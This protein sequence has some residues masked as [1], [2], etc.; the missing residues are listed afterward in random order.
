MLLGDCDPQASLT[1]SLGVPKPDDLSVTLPTLMRRVL[2]E[3]PMNP[4]EAIIHHEEGVDLLPANIELA[5]MELRLMSAM[6]R[7]TIL[8]QVLEP[9]RKQYDHILMWPPASVY[10]LKVLYSPG[11]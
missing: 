1:I 7:E 10:R 5:G 4:T 6:S 9:L 3:A 8:R 11:R 2:E